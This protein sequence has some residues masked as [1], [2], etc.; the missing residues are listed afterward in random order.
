M[1]APDHHQT[2]GLYVVTITAALDGYALTH[3]LPTGIDT[4]SA[5]LIL[6]TWHGIAAV[7]INWAFGSSSQTSK[8]SDQLAAATPATSPNAAQVSADAATPADRPKG[9]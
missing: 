3:G 4:G 5:G 9:T 1:R 7:V 6:G 2:L 8:L